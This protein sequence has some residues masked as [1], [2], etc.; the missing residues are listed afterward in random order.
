MGL[1]IPMLIGGGLGLLTK[2]TKGILPGAA[3]G[4]LGGGIGN[5]MKGGSFLAGAAEAA[6]TAA[7]AGAAPFQGAVFNSS[8]GT[9]LNPEYYAG[10][11][12]PLAT[13]T[14]GQGLLSN[15]MGN[16]ASAIPDYVTPQN[17]LGAANILSNMDAS[18]TPM[19]ASSGGGMNRANAIQTVKFGMATPIQRKKGNIYG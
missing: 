3:L 17:V 15:A 12:T 14:G 8:T 2:G 16:V 6:P 7:S 10:A 19:A 1:G 18:H 11:S 5:L 4:G 13:Y 9:F